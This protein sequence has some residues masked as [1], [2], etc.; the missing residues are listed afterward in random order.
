MILNLLMKIDCVIPFCKNESF[1]LPNASNLSL[2][3]QNIIF[4]RLFIYPEPETVFIER[5]VTVRKS[6]RK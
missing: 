2:G 6:S 4:C 5:Q 3:F 1:S